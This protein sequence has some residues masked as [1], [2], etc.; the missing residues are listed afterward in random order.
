MKTLEISIDFMDLKT[1]KYPYI[2]TTYP[3]ELKLTGLIE[4]VNEGMY[5]NFQCILNFTN[6]FIILNFKVYRGLQWSWKYPNKL[7]Q[8]KNKLI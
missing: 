6:F 1:L 3:I 5:T 4:Q 2:K 7:K 8:L